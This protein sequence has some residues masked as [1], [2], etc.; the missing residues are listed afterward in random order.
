MFY[1]SVSIIIPIYNV[2]KYLDECLK[3][4]INQSYKDLDIILVDDGSS[5]NS[6]NIAKEYAKKDERIFLITKENG[7]LSS[8]RNAGLEFIKGTK[9]REFFENESNITSYEN[10]NTFNTASKEL[11]K[12]DINKNFTKLS[13]NIIQ[14][15]LKNIND[16]II[17]DLP[18]NIIHFLDSDD[19]LE[20]DCIEKCVNEMSK[21]DLDICVHSYVKYDETKKEMKKDIHFEFPKKLKNRFYYDY[22]LDTLYINSIYFFCFAWQG[23][24]NANILNKYRLR[25][26]HGVY[27]EDTDFGVLLFSLAK[28]LIYLDY[29]GLIYRVR[30]NSITSS[31]NNQMP[32]KLPDFLQT[33]RKYYDNYN[34][35]R[36]YFKIFCFA[37]NALNIWNFFNEKSNLDIN[38]KKK[39]KKFFQ[40]YIIQLMDVFKISIDDDPYEIK[41]IWK[42][43][44]ISKRQH[45]LK[46]LKDI[47]RHPKKIKNIKNLFY[48]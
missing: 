2:E 44:K 18:N 39:Y 24:F 13:K 48:L 42:Q 7:G 21:S 32:E 31:E 43:I 8:A 27:Y 4:V 26:T 29:C 6:L 17:Q 28:K 12:E 47:L 37:T 14:T 11:T 46:L 10:I 45:I 22:A 38:F 15:K 40:N 20:L 33:L 16:F 41:K 30:E 9:L 5:D 19:Y 36:K 1:R 3:S 23:S 25:F 34:E 35:L